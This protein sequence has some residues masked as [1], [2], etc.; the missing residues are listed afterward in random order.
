[1][2]F[3]YK[4]TF[5][6]HFNNLKKFLETYAERERLC[7]EVRHK[8]WLNDNF[9]TLFGA[10]NVAM[11]LNDLYYMPRLTKITADFT[12]IRLLGNRKLIPDDFSHLRVDRAKDLDW[13]HDWI[14]KFL[15]DDLEV[16][17]YSNNRYE[18]HPPATIKELM[19]KF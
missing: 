4:F 12:Y 16:F 13:W 3:D 19:A 11:V 9:Y 6:D 2:Q 18:G 17:A 5:Q 7:V 8:S 14:E 1:L 10:H 15:T